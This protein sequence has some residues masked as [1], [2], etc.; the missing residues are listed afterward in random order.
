MFILQPMDTRTAKPAE[1]TPVDYEH[2][3]NLAK[4]MAGHID[5]SEATIANRALGAGNSKFFQRLRDG[6]GCLAH[7]YEQVFVWLGQNWPED[8]EWPVTIPRPRTIT[9]RKSA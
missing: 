8:L 9:R 6:R 7:K 2:L 5:R 4:L 1:Y 3:V